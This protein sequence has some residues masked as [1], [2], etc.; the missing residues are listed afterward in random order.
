MAAKEGGLARKL[1]I[2]FR[3]ESI[4][5]LY[6]PFMICLASSVLDPKT[7]AHF[8]SQQRFFLKAFTQAYE[9]AEECADDDDDKVSV[10]KLKKLV[11]KKLNEHSDS[12][13]DW[14]FE[15][16]SEGTPDSTTAKYT[17]FLISTASGK[18]EGEKFPGKIATPFE[19]TKLA[20]YTL[21]AMAPYM[22]FYASISKEILALQSLNHRDHPYKKWIS[23]LSAL[24]YEGVALEVD[25]LLEKLSVSLTGEELEVVEKIYH[26]ALRH[27]LQFFYALPMFQ[28][29]VALSPQLHDPVERD[30]S[31]FCDFDMTCTAIDSS[32]I[33][34]EIA[35]RTARKADVDVSEKLVRMSSTDVRNTWGFISNRY[36]DEY[37]QCIDSISSGEKVGKFDYEGL[38]QALEQVAEFE[39][40]ANSRVIQSGVLKGLNRED[41]KRAGE[42]L[43]FQEGCK[44]FFQEITKCGNLKANTHCLSYCWCG[45][46]IRS[47]FSSGGM[48]IEDVYCNELVSEDNVTTGDM[49]RKIESP[50]EKHEAFNRKVGKES[51]HVSICVG[52]TVGD[53]L[54]LLNADIGIAIKPSH[55]LTRVGDK[56]GIIFFP[57]FTGLAM[58][59]IEM[60]EN[61]C[62]SKGRSGIVYTVSSW[63]EI[64]AFVFGI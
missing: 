45:D 49:V 4:Y 62:I 12:V 51:S 31:I 5:V 11:M 20:A 32:A 17:D 8:L 27:K 10:R 43:V 21:A 15:L 7:F 64:H 13:R 33:L 9:L 41:V 35:I 2:K 57:L 55:S 3:N 47:A 38:C 63:A 22:R 59:Q 6:S 52:G 46:M 1:W 34:A 56:F 37:E 16:P 26:Q 29:T 60:T 14:G 30:F 50:M 23:S 44:G 25:D 40:S 58:K 48:N 42:H 54:C 36:T 61:G 39:K 18:V 28:K 24:N 19:K 53:V